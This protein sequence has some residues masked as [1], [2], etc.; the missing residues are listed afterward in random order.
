M[1]FKPETLRV[2]GSED[3]SGSFG[4]TAQLW[5]SC[6]SVTTVCPAVAAACSAPCPL[7]SRWLTLAPFSS[8]NSQANSEPC[9]PGADSEDHSMW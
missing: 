1:K 2:H 5:C 3:L 9:E 6:A 4:F 7:R 8:R